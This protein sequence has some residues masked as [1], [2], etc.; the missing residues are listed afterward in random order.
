MGRKM[1]DE[2]YLELGR[3]AAGGGRDLVA[4]VRIGIVRVAFNRYC[5]EM[6]KNGL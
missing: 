5:E 3:G 1:R 6:E 2:G 4:I